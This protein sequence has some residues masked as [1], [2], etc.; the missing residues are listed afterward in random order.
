[1]SLLSSS[2]KRFARQSWGALRRRGT[3]VA[4]A[5]HRRRLAGTTFVAI[6]GSTGKSMTKYLVTEVLAT[7]GQ[8]AST[9][10]DWNLRDTIAR[11]VLGTSSSDRYCV[12]EA[13]AMSPRYLAPTLR[14]LRPRIGIVTNIGRDHWSAFGSSEAIAEEKGNVVRCLGPDGI[15]VLNADDPFVSAMATSTKARVITFGFGDTADVRGGDLH[16]AWPAPLSLTVRYGNEA[17]RVQTQ[18]YGHHWHGAVLAA[19]ATGL[20]E[21]IP[22]ADCAEA[23]SRVPPRVGRMSAETDARGVTFIRDDWKASLPSIGPAI[24]VLATANARRKIAVFGTI[25]DCPGNNGRWY[26]RTARAALDAADIVIFVGA[27]AS[28]AMAVKR[29]QVGDRLLAFTR[30]RDVARFLDQTLENGD[31]VLLKGCNPADHLSRLALAR[32]TTVRC[33]R[34]RCGRGYFCSD[35]NLLTIDSGPSAADDQPA[36]TTGGGVPGAPSPLPDALPLVIGLGN[37]GREFKGTPHN[38]GADIIDELAVSL[39]AE[40]HREGDAM[41]AMVER[42]GRRFVLVK[43]EVPMNH[44]GDA[45][46]RLGERR[47]VEPKDCVLVFDDMDLPLG[48]VRVR[49]R[50]SSGGHRGVASILTTFQSDEFRRVKIGVGKPGG[51]KLTPEELLTPFGPDDAARLAEASRDAITRVLELV[52]P[53]PDRTGAGRRAVGAQVQADRV[54]VQG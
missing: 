27:Q 49:Q 5:I 7:R 41:V 45:L 33:W 51:G 26:R 30:I 37:P 53:M 11:T 52:G 21:G 46:R 1:M 17:V 10:N 12:V 48:K 40:W 35:C 22:L 47:S 25:S 15:A 50:G 6:T 18:L 34:D 16:S 2:A 3:R 20:A 31:L 54:E 32:H 36:A 39:G 23:V 29:P 38:I 8:C 14:L 42:E 43:F 4:A 9:R 24:D 19:I 44:A 28:L 13:A